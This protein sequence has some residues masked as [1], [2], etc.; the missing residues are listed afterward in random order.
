ME[1]PTHILLTYGYFLLFAWVLIEQLGIPLPATPV[2]LAA[3]YSRRVTA[4][5]AVAAIATGTAVTLAWDNTGMAGG[6]VSAA[7]IA[8]D[9]YYWQKT[10]TQNVRGQMAMAMKVTGSDLGYF[11]NGTLSA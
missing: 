1:L 10:K 2:V 9:Q 3:F 8:I 4:W 7:G 6:N 5:G 11:I